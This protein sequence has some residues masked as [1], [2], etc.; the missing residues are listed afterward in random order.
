VSCTETVLVIDDSMLIHNLLDVWLKPENVT[1]LHSLDGGTGV[2]MAVEKQP[3]LILLDLVLEQESGFD[4][5][6]ILMENPDTRDIPVVI[7]TGAADT[8][9]KVRCLDAGAVDY[10]TKPFD[11]AELR[12]R[13]RVGLRLRRYQQLL[14]R[15]ARLDALTGSWNRGF[16]EERMHAEVATGWRYGRPVGFMLVDVDN[17]KAINDTYGHAAGDRALQ[18]IADLLKSS[19]RVGDTFGRF[20]GDEFGIIV[21]ETGPVGMARLVERLAELTREMRD[22]TGGKG[23]TVSIGGALL[24]QVCAASPEAAVSELYR[25]ADTALYAAKRAGRN[26]GVFYA[27]EPLVDARSAVNAA[28]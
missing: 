7:L 28:R 1:V 26:R 11:P 20:G 4:V 27:D 16:L 24:S 12:A 3:S 10:I 6:R 15:Q 13:V 17:F 22:P 19:L 14:A 18:A 2:A 9:N 21:R 8:E 5:V 25:A 23:L